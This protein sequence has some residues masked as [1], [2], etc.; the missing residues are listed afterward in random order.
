VVLTNV[1]SV[2]KRIILLSKL[3][4]DVYCDTG[5]VL[6]CCGRVFVLPYFIYLVHGSCMFLS[7]TYK[8]NNHNRECSS[9]NCPFLNNT[10]NYVCFRDSSYLIIFEEGWRTFCRCSRGNKRKTGGTSEV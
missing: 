5:T 6:L 1:F 4:S 3:K 7:P 8:F 9:Q 10:H 2:L